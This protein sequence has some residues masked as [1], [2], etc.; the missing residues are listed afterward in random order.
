[1]PTEENLQRAIHA[2]EGLV[3]IVTER[4]VAKQAYF[5][6][7]CYQEGM[8]GLAEAIKRFDPGRKLK[9]ATYAPHWIWKYVHREMLKATR[10]IRLPINNAEKLGKI[11]KFIER[12]A[13]T[14]EG[15]KPDI[16]QITAGTKI[17]EKIILDLLRVDFTIS[18][19]KV[20]THTDTSTELIGAIRDPKSV[21]LATQ[22]TDE[23]DDTL[24]RRLS[25]AMTIAE[26]TL[27]EAEVFAMRSLDQGWLSEEKI[28]VQ[29]QAPTASQLKHQNE[30]YTRALHKLQGAAERG[31]LSL[32]IFTAKP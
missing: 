5:F 4:Y 25:H 22:L 16:V 31:E 7:D 11:K 19:N 17:E 8:L 32:E 12:Y 23:I 1:V 20:P 6:D 3:K 28:P 14:H 15:D 26:L 29:A 13:A 27:K 18:L 30:L 2:N 24:K 21:G 9:I 10:N